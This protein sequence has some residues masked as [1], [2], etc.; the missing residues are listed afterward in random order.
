LRFIHNATAI[1]ALSPSTLTKLDHAL[2]VA[3]ALE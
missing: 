2:A 1:G 3:L